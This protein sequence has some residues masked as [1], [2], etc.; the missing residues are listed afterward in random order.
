MRVRGRGRGCLM[1]AAF[2]V[3]SLMESRG[4]VWL[5]CGEKGKRVK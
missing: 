3:M 2:S 5:G 4:G 1:L